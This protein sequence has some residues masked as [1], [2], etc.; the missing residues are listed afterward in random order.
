MRNWIGLLAL[1]LPLCGQGLDLKFLDK[2]ADKAGN[3]VTITLDENLLRLGTSVLSLANDRDARDL[4]DAV[5][6]LRSITVRS[7]EF[8]KD[9]EVSAADVGAITRQLAGWSQV[10]SVRE[11]GE[12]TGVWLKAGA[13]DIGGLVIVTH[14]PRQLTVVSIEGNIDLEKLGRLSGKMGIPDIPTGRKPVPAPK[15]PPAKDNPDQDNEEIQ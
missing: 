13:K 11:K 6:G 10:V 1:A 9:G 5:S 3:V 8:D 4:K 15:A 14:Q 2:Y 7:F 12:N